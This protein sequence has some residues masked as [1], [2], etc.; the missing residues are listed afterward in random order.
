MEQLAENKPAEAEIQN[1]EVVAGNALDP[2]MEK[3][4]DNL[5]TFLKT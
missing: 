4:L 1:E 3:N 2:A 5:R